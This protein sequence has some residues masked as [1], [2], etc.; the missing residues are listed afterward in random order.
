RLEQPAAGRTTDLSA[1]LQR[2]VEVVKKRALM[3]LISDLLAPADALEKNLGLLTA[4]GHE[5]MLF[6][7]L[8]PAELTF[9]FERAVMFHDV[10]SGRDLFIDPATAR[11]QY[12]KKLNAHIDDVRSV[13]QRQGIGYR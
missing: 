10:E 6:H 2:I 8:N 12:L 4:C 1:P 3:V 13:C 5:V 11:K 9:S 7:I